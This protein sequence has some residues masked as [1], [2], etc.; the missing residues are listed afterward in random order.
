MKPVTF[1]NNLSPDLM[2]WM[3]KYSA[4]HNV[5][6]RAVLEKALNEFRKSV[7]QKEYAVSFKKASL[8]KEIKSMTEDGLS[9]YFSQLSYLEK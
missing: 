9:D 7:R 1:T 6:R 2:N 5:T 3:E 4:Y 8:D